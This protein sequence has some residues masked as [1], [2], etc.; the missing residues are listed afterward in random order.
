ML[1]Y[2]FLLCLCISHIVLIAQ[3]KSASDLGFRQLEFDYKGDKVD[4]LII[5]KAGEANIKKP[6]FFF[7][8]GS[9]PQPLIKFRGE[10]MYSILPFNTSVLEE[11]YHIVL[12]SKPGIPM[13]GNVENLG[14]YYM[15]LD[16]Q[17]NIPDYYQARNYLSY[18]VNRNIA[19][20][21]FL[22]KQSNFH[23]NNIVVA[24]HSEGST[25]AAKMASQ[26]KKI[27]QLIYSAGNPLGRILSIIG[28]ANAESE[29]D[30]MD[31]WA[32]IVENKN[33]L[34]TS[35]GDTPKATYEFS[36]N[37]MPDFIKMKIPVLIIYGTRDWSAPFNDYLQVETIRQQK[38][39]FTFKTYWNCEHNY[40]PMQ[41][42]NTPNYDIDNWEKVG[43]NI[44]EWILANP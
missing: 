41:S 24:G 29:N 43:E 10:K 8:Q 18:Y 15:Y 17:G 12:V 21:D 1:K 40:Y 6:I 32:Y 31:Y 16:A 5:S 19:V 35:F 34:D 33:S 28:Q 26:Y 42:D 9:L 44:S 3:E 4:I 38:K 13:V 37:L 27:S 30:L 23:K 20:L 14:K 11:K 22:T 36:C 7:V 2:I 25:I 39:N